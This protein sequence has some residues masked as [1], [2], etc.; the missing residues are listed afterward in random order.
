[1]DQILRKL[2][3]DSPKG[4]ISGNTL[5]LIAIATMFIDHLGAGILEPYIVQNYDMLAVS[6]RLDGLLN[7]NLF[8]R[9]V[10]RIAFPIFCFLIAEGF[11]HTRSVKKYGIRLFVFSLISEVPFDLVF[12]GSWFDPLHQNVYFTLFIGLL[13]LAGC[14]R[15]QFETVLKMAVVLAG[16][17]AAFLLR[18]DYDMT[19]VVMIAVLYELRGDKRYQT[20]AGGILAALES[21][22]CFCSAVLAFIPIPMYNGTR[23]RLKLKYFFY[24]FYP[25]H[26]LLFY[27]IQRMITG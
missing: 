22:A 2:G 26:L 19:G 7:L 11:L 18:C 27:L 21:M 15:W 25:V 10:G 24:W 5:K 14:R 6:G 17:V 13:V 16:C 9:T 20:I 1:M 23:G 8:L 12:F 4:G 3:A